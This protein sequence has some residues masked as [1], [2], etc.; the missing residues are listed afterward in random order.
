MPRGWHTPN[1]LLLTAMMR[2]SVRGLV[3]D[4][5]ADSRSQMQR[6]DNGQTNVITTT[7]RGMTDRW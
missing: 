2:A 4:H 7:R 3:R 6:S 5:L 1:V